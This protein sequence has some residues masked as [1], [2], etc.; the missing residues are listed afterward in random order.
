MQRPLCGLWDCGCHLLLVGAQSRV[1]KTKGKGIDY[2]QYHEHMNTVSIHLIQSLKGSYGSRAQ[3]VKV[4]GA[5]MDAYDLYKDF[6][7][8]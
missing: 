7:L 1:L 2:L 8:K 5:T 4:K 6:F 3:E